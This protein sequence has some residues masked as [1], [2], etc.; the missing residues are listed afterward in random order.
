MS[1]AKYFDHLQQFMQDIEES[2]SNPTC[3]TDDSISFDTARMNEAIGAACQNHGDLRRRRRYG[4]VLFK[5]N[6]F[7]YYNTDK[8]NLRWHLSW[9]DAGGQ[10]S[11]KC[12]DVFNR[13]LYYDKCQLALKHLC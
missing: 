4:A 3:S 6:T 5:R 13:M 10:C 11:L 7:S 12:E 8:D 2:V 1:D 9:D